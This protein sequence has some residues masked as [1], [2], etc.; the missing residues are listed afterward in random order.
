MSREQLLE[1]GFGPG[2][3]DHRKAVGRL[4]LVSRGV[5][6]VGHTHTCG[7][8]ANWTALL[9]CGPEAVLS[10]RS[11]AAAWGVLP[12]PAT[13]VQLTV[14][15]QRGRTRRREGI[16]VHRGSVPDTERARRGGF[17][18][19]SLARTFLDLAA[20]EPP[21]VVEQALDSAETQRN[22]DMRAIDALAPEG[23]TR[24]GAAAFRAVLATHLPGTTI[25]KSDLEEAMLSLCR[26]HRLPRPVF[27]AYVEGWEVDVVWRAERLCVEVQSTRYHATSQRI[28]R[29]AEKEA[30]LMAA[31]WAVLH[32]ADR[33]VLH[34]PDRVADR[35]LAVLAGRSM[36]I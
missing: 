7:H 19:T 28:A 26:R 13:I 20:T 29:D 36:V 21:R 9:A 12:W 3:I 18:V 27:N 22:F 11:A 31:G 16:R 17:P 30:D 25:T 4:H 1:L 10:H 32:V 23:S 33:H 5:Y 15:N 35:V 14:P 6:A 2:A 8:A 34:E 24:P